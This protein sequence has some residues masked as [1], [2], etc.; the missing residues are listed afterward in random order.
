MEEYTQVSEN[1]VSFR[2]YVLKGREYFREVLRYWYIPAVLGLLF[3]AYQIYKYS[4][5][6]PVYPA[7]ITFSVDED[8]GGG[9]SA[10]TGMLSQF[11][12]GAVRPAR[13]NFDKI[14]ELGRSRRVVQESMFS[15]ITVDGKED[16][17][18]NHVIRIYEFNSPDSEGTDD[19][20]FYFTHDSLP[21]FTRREN[22]V[23]KSLYHF[24][25]GPPNKPE[26]A[27]LSADYNEDTNIMS[28]T[29]TTKD[30][31]LSIQL[32][33]KMF[34]SLSNYYINKAIEKSLKTFKIVTAKRDSVLG[35]LRSAEYQLAN[36]KDRNRGMLLRTDYVSELRLQRDVTALAAMY[37]EVLKNVEVA[38]FSLRNKTP[39][40]QIIDAPIPPI[41]PT[42][43]SLLRKIA[44]GL[45]IGGLIGIVIVAGRKAY[46]DLMTDDNDSR[47]S[48]SI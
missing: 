18:A 48:A 26:L 12:L 33:R 25:I 29:A 14:L 15:K 24:I 40:I 28:L 35:E 17:I 43:L 37:G 9:Q 32:A 31:T 47:Y 22:E 41:Q 16:F 6:V 23:L 44:L 13:Y 5:Y 45:I 34:E 20:P 19:G 2:Q 10:L 27:L 1:E 7:T 30:E 46:R 11:G 8:E 38:D 39:F 21:A 3:A 4:I 36:F 42:Q